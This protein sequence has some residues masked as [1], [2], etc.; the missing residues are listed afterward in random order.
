[1]VPSTGEKHLLREPA[2][3]QDTKLGASAAHLQDLRPWQRKS[4]TEDVYGVFL[5]EK[6]KTMHRL[7][8]LHGSK[9]YL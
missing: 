7:T 6:R 3:A 9:T 1:M 8:G 5:Q 4:K 2:E